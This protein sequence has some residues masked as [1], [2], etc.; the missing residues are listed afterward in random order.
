[1]PVSCAGAASVPGG[2]CAVRAGLGFALSAA[3]GNRQKPDEGLI[4]SC[5]LP[6][7]QY[8]RHGENKAALRAAMLSTVHDA[9]QSR[10][11][12]IQPNHTKE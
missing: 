12:Y 10:L 8:H 9:G 11:Q 4:C 7:F 1:M 3:A 2:I 6:E 5:E